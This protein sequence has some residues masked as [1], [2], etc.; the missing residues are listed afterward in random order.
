MF[1]HSKTDLRA[2]FR[3]LANSLSENEPEPSA[4]LLEILIPAALNCSANLK[5][6]FVSAFSAKSNKISEISIYS[7]LNYLYEIEPCALRSEL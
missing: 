3:K 4:I 2:I 5:N 7:F 6:F 1:T